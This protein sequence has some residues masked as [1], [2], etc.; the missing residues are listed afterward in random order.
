LGRKRKK[1]RG[2]NQAE[3]IAYPLS[4]YLKQNYSPQMLR[5]TRETRTQIGLSFNERSENVKVAFVAD[6]IKAKGRSILLIDDVYTSGA[7]MRSAAQA[8][9]DGGAKCVYS[10]TAT[11]AINWPEQDIW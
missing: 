4:N 5:R 6:S 7:T 11:R 9:K 1:E 3:V 2:Y 8:L 10:L